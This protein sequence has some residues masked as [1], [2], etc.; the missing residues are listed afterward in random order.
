[1]EFLVLGNVKQLETMNSITFIHYCI[2]MIIGSI[3][4]FARANITNAQFPQWSRFM[5]TCW[6][7]AAAFMVLFSFYKIITAGTIITITIK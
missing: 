3:F 1:M 4:V 7:I 5:L 2:T 6:R